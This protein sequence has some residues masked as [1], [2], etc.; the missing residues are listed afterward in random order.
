MATPNF[1]LD[2]NLVRETWRA[3]IEELL[4]SA[5]K[6]PWGKHM[7]IAPK[8]DG[9]KVSDM[10]SGRLIRILPGISGENGG[11]K[12]TSAFTGFIVG[13]GHAGPGYLPQEAVKVQTGSS[14][15]ELSVIKAPEVG[16]GDGLNPHSPIK[17]VDQLPKYMMGWFGDLFRALPAVCLARGRGTNEG[18]KS[19]ALVVEEADDGT[20]S[21]FIQDYFNSAG[22]QGAVGH[23]ALVAH[24]H[25]YATTEESQLKKT[26]AAAK[27]EDSLAA[28]DVMTARHVTLFCQAIKEMASSDLNFEP[29]PMMISNDMRSYMGGDAHGCLFVPERVANNLKF[30]AGSYG[31]LTF[32]REL[33][34]SPNSRDA[35]FFNGALPLSVN[36][37]LIYGMGG[38]DMGNGM[39]VH[40]N[41]TGVSVASGI[42]GS[43][44]AMEMLPGSTEK[45]MER[46]P[47]TEQR[48]R[49]MAALPMGWRGMDL[50]KCFY[51]ES[52]DDNRGTDFGIRATMLLGMRSRRAKHPVSGVVSDYRSAVLYSA[53]PND[54]V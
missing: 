13:E 19:N 24:T 42:Y 53:M 23:N 16:I 4:G 20:Q 17:T 18:I 44:D 7:A 26:T 41:S 14:Q 39:R 21:Q 54:I 46:I 22:I 47:G 15:I 51:A 5:E 11:I 12:V 9:G 40:K 52:W 2:N 33:A 1:K 37:V 8:M 43:V 35:L 25:A 36:G 32:H 29:R 10:P 45:D 50:G 31:V 6:N 3:G 49:N 48:I 30:D 28:G 27:S 38:Y 34:A